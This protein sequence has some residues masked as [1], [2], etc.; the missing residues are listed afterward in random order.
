MMISG[1]LR[2]LPIPYSQQAASLV[3]MCASVI[4][5]DVMY[6][7]AW[8]LYLACYAYGSGLVLSPRCPTM[9]RR[10]TASEV[11]GFGFPVTNKNHY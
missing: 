10:A 1:K 3:N 9:R 2:A 7:R 11:A 5:N 6:D 8:C 4:M